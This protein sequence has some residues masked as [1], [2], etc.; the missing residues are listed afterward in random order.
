MG[1]EDE[2]QDFKALLARTE[3]TAAS[4]TNTQ[5]MDLDHLT[6]ASP[7]VSSS[8]YDKASSGPSFKVTF[9]LMLER[10]SR[11]ISML[12][13]FYPCL[14]GCVVF[15]GIGLVLY[16][17]GSLIFNPTVEY[18]VMQHDHSFL[19]SKYN[20]QVS[21]IDHWCLR[22][23]NDSCKCEDPLTPTSRADR[24]CM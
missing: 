1:P 20:L 21:Q 18:G 15:A 3:K 8:K 19:D 11:Y 7:N 5:Q 10:L 2:E 6:K 4:S 12:C 16:G 9:F 24:K 14:C 22:G 23:D 13:Y 17:L